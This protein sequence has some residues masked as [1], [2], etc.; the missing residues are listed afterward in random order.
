[1]IGYHLDTGDPAPWVTLSVTFACVGVHC[2]RCRVTE[3]LYWTVIGRDCTI[4][5]RAVETHAKCQGET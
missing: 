5:R 1:V 3:G 2:S 4:V